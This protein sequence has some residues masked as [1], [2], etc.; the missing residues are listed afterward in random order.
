MRNNISQYKIA[1]ISIKIII[2]FLK[3]DII[4]NSYMKLTGY[5]IPW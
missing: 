1:N 3:K 2:I 5:Y 4:P